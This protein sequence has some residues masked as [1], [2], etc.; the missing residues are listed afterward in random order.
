L[1]PYLIPAVVFGFLAWRFLK[2]R[3]A[4]AR[5]PGLLSQGAVVVDVRSA[6]EYSGGA[7]EGSLNIPLADLESGADKLDRQRPVVLC[8]ASGTRSAMAAAL[9]KRKGF[10][11]VVNAG[12]WRNTIL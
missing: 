6:A 9:L 1:Q 5:L 2:F 10:K 8:C 4:R 12:S 3:R 11:N 7:R